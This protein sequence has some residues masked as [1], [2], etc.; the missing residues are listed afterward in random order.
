MSDQ[1]IELPPIEERPLVT[2]ALFAYNQEKYIREAVEGAFSQTYEPLEIILSDDCSTDRTFEIMQDMASEYKGP[3]KVVLNRNE[4][5]VGVCGHINKVYR[6]A[7]SEILVLAA[8]DDISMPQRTLL[9]VE[10]FNS[11][12][13]VH[14]VFSDLETINELSATTLSHKSSWR[15]GQEI[16][17]FK[18]LHQGGGVG[19]GASYSYRNG[20]FNWPWELP[21]DIKSEDK[22]LPLRAMLLGGLLHITQPLVRYRETSNSLTMQLISSKQLSIMNQLHLNELERTMSKARECGKIDNRTAKICSRIIRELPQY[23]KFIDKLMHSNGKLT[24]RN[25]IIDLWYNREK[26]IELIIQKIT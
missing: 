20:C 12:P 7:K 17:L 19:T 26:A 9:I 16:T 15:E 3:H 8:G 25:R 14:A 2:F 24:M 6:L 22:L 18:L 13:K 4:S 11:N 23:K 10:A 21:S 5:N 1:D